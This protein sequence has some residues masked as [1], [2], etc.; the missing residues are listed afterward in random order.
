MTIDLK[1]SADQR[2]IKK[3][4]NLPKSLVDEFDL[5]VEAAKDAYGDYVDE[6]QVMEAILTKQLKDRKFRSWLSKR[7]NSEKSSPK[8]SGKKNEQPAVESEIREAVSSDA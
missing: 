1:I 5:Y 6:N 7:K 8:A 3:A 4:F 2:P